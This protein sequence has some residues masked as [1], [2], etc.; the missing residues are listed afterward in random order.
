MPFTLHSHKF[1]LY[2]YESIVQRWLMVALNATKLDNSRRV[3]FS[4]IF[5]YCEVIFIT[6]VAMHHS[7]KKKSHAFELWFSMHGDIKIVQE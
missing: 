7:E 1:R 2:S 3:F 6:R 4:Y 5:F